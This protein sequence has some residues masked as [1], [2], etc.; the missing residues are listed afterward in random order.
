MMSLGAEQESALRAQHVDETL[1]VHGTAAYCV[2]PESWRAIW[3]EID[4]LRSEVA[5]A[6]GH[7]AWMQ[8]VIETL[9]K[10]RDAV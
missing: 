10:E 7:L 2:S 4:R 6:R 3:G 5:D 1:L 8:T 9:R